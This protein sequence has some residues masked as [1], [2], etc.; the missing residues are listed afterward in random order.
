MSWFEV[1]FDS[2]LYDKMYAKRDDEEA[3]R[4]A[5]FLEQKIPVNKY[6]EILDLGCGR[7]RHSINFAKRGYQVTG[8]DLSE[9]AIK[10]AEEKAQ[11]EN[12][13]IDFLVGD[14]RETLDRKFDCIINLFTS[15]GYFENDNEN[16]MVLQAMH[17]MMRSDGLL[18]IDYL[19]AQQVKNN[20]KSFE[21]GEIDNIHYKIHRFI[22]GDTVNKKMEFYKNDNNDTQI[23]QERVKLYDQD[24]FSQNLKKEGLKIDEI[25]GDYMGNPINT[26]NSSRLLMICSRIN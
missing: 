10:K 20:I 2:P 9:V 22:E 24:W 14:M 18:V 15:F 5:N 26:V 13:H 3:N 21:E 1:W 4:L 7:G 16:R 19:N 25:Y 8:I 23:Y 12:L 17:D 11:Q 6:P